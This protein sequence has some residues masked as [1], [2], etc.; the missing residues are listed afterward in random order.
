MRRLRLHSDGFDAQL[1]P[2]RDHVDGWQ[3]HTLAPRDGDGPKRMPRMSQPARGADVKQVD[4][5]LPAGHCGRRT[6]GC[7]DPLDCDCT[8]KLCARQKFA[9]FRVRPLNYQPRVMPKQKPHRSVQIVSTPWP[10]IDYVEAQYGRITWDLAATAKNCKVRRA[11]RV[12]GKR[13]VDDSRRFGPGARHEDAL[14]RNWARKKGTLW[15][16][17]E[18]SNIAKWVKKAAE[19]EFTVET[20]LVMLIPASVGS[21]WWAEHVHQRALVEF[22][23]PRVKFRGHKQGYPKDLALLIYGG[24]GEHG[25]SCRRWDGK[26]D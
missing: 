13:L 6:H 24:I 10:L 5:A 2:R 3:K 23:R 15:L 1:Q 26:E 14:K 21:N 18:F 22:I 8:C 16:N 4:R 20:K 19:T 11:T 17:P 9:D 25:Y 7:E 12:I